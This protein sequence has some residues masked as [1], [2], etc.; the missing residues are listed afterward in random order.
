MFVDLKAFDNVNREILW[1]TLRR[2]GISEALVE[3]IKR[4]Y[5]ET[6]IR[7]RTNQEKT[8]GFIT[9]KGVW[10]GCGISPLLF[11]LYIAELEEEFKKR[12]IGGVQVENSRIWSLAYA[13]DF[14]LLA[15]NRDAMCDMIR[16]FGTFLKKRMEIMYDKIKDIGI[17]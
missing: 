7:V 5:E 6:E 2:Q 4:M 14:V 10:Q 13:D 9:H 16:T 11:N 12:N 15:K 3:R 8:E 17:Q 1:D